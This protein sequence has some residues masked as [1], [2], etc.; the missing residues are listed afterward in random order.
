MLN[1]IKI[2][3]I[4]FSPDFVF[5]VE[6]KRV[7]FENCSVSMYTNK[8]RNNKFY[9]QYQI[10]VWIIFP[11]LAKVENPE[12][13]HKGN[14]K[15]DRKWVCQKR[16]KRFSSN[17]IYKPFYIFFRL[18]QS[19]ITENLMKVQISHPNLSCQK[20]VLQKKKRFFSNVH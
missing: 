2:F 13:G 14:R 17:L 10:R 5:E 18:Y 6:S 12:V 15:W 19:F 7:V 11:G 16:L 8:N 4:E 9:K 1:S 3:S 20:C